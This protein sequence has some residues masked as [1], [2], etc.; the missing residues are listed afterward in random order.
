MVAIVDLFK[1]RFGFRAQGSSLRKGH[2]EKELA[3]F[4]GEGEV[5]GPLGKSIGNRTGSEIGRRGL[6]PHHGDGL[7]TGE[8]SA[9]QVVEE[10]EKSSSVWKRSSDVPKPVGFG[11][12]DL[13]HEPQRS[14][15]VGKFFGR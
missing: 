2:T 1:Q 13:G 6:I 9:G 4:G 7:G 11:E 5:L 14:R 12:V 15:T 10:E 3:R 8:V